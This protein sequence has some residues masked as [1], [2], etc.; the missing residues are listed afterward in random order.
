LNLAIEY[1]Q[2]PLTA[3]AAEKTA[4]I[5]ADTTGQFTRMPFGLSGAVAE[6]TKLMQRVLGPLQGK[7]VR[8]YLDDMVIDVRDWPELLVKLKLDSKTH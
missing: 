3:E 4:F 6:F 8:N 7:T 2:I 5:T 1:L